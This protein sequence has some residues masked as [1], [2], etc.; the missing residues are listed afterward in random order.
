[1]ELAQFFESIMLI[2]FGAAWPISI[3]K[4]YKTKEARG[5]SRLFLVVVMI[6]YIAGIFYKIYGRM[7]AIICLYILNF[8]MVFIDFILCC[9][10]IKRYKNTFECQSTGG[11]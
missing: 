4:L 7:D 6:G 10:Y 1:M 11:N 8:I 5:K 3:Y 2:C 9:K